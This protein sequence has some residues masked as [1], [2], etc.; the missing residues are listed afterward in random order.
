MN[1]LLH[2]DFYKIN[3]G[4]QYPKGTTKVYSYLCARKG[5]G[6]EHNKVLFFGLKYYIEKYLKVPTKEEVE[7]FIVLADS[8]CPLDQDTKDR[9]RSL[10]G[11]KEL[12]I[13]IKAL[14][15]FVSYPV[16]TP[17]VSVTNTHPDYFWLPNYI[18]GLLLKLWYPC[19]VATL[20]NRYKEISDKYAEQTC[21]ND[22]HVLYQV[23]D[24]GY[25]GCSSEESAAIAGAAFLIN[26]KGSDNIIAA[27]LLNDYY[28][29][30]HSSASSVPATEHSVMCSSGPEGELET[31]ERMLD[32]YPT[33][34]V[35]VVSDT[36][37]YWNVIDNVLP[38][39]KDRILERDGKFVVRPDSGDP[40]EIIPHTIDKL[41]NLFGYTTNSKGYKELNPKIGL[42]YGDA[43]Y[44]ERFER[45]L[46]RLEELGWAS[47]N[48]VVGVGGIM[49]QN[50]SRDDYGFAMK[51]SYIEVNGEPR[52]I[53]KCPKT[54]TK[55]KSHKGMLAVTVD[56]IDN[57]LVINT[58]E[59]CD[60]IL[61]NSGMMKVVY[62]GVIDGKQ[63]RY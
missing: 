17:L 44:I 59:E 52:N 7:E 34:I 29:I 12:P 33:G 48:L 10:V 13:R 19:S 25:R 4:S 8:I 49:L 30:R 1:L 40:E 42:I 58:I 3:H 5:Y 61:E 57:K 26:Y 32:L 41:G 28:P 45:I 24:F 35:S 38:A 55:K 62:E 15:E 53:F 47:S 43:I 22:S 60:R 9:V 14:P 63:Y 6:T 27:K 11:L 46:H 50:H 23:H 37:D 20:S 21:D 56:Y 18:E 36:Y 39:L 31:F 51:A 2:T 16:G 54:D